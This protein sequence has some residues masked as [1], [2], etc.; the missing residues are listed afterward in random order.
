MGRR[1]HGGREEGKG[2]NFRRKRKELCLS[3]AKAEQKR[4][5]PTKAPETGKLKARPASG[6]GAGVNATSWAEAVANAANATTTTA[7][8]LII[9]IWAISRIYLKLKK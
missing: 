6:D 3:R 2:W 8:F 1:R 7:S 4:E 9:L 5:A